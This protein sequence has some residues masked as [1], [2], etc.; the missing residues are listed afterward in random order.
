MG[1]ETDPFSYGTIAAGYLKK[2][3][4]KKVHIAK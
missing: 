1:L 3:L 4:N 2:V